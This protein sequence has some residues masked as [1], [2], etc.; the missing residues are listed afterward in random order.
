[1]TTNRR[2]ILMDHP[3]NR[4]TFL[5][6]TVAATGV[7]AMGFHQSRSTAAESNSPLEKY[8]V[9]QSYSM[10][11]AKRAKPGCQQSLELNLLTGNWEWCANG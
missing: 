2:E 8:A 3:F 9:S 7:L 10:E 11:P 6:H 5:G 1:M 4:R